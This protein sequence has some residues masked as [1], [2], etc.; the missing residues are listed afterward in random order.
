[1]SKKR[2]D[3]YSTLEETTKE[4]MADEPIVEKAPEVVETI[5]VVANC[6]RLN[7]RVSPRIT[8]D[9]LTIIDKGTKV[10]LCPKQPKNDEWCRVRVDAKTEGF[11]MK[12]YIEIQ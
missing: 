12:K 1:M 5:G 8:A 9:R 3:S 4:V 6:D 10:V 11:C 2:H 7:V